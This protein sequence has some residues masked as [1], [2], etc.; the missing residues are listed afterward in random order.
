[1]VWSGGNDIKFDE[2]VYVST[3]NDYRCIL[4]K[5]HYIYSL[6]VEGFTSIEECNDFIDKLKIAINWF[7]LKRVIG[8]KLPDKLNEVKLYKVPIT[9]AEKSGLKAVTDQAGWSVVDGDYN[10]DQLVIIQENMKLTRWETGK[11]A[12]LLSHNAKKVFEDLNE[13]LCFDNVDDLRANKKLRLAV[14]LFSA[15]KFEVTTT[16]KF[17]KLVTVLEALLPDSQINETS[18]EALGLAKKAVKEYINKLK[19]SGENIQ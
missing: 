17:V 4:E 2:N 7:S 12:F 16:G 13:C 14:E 6:K 9:I 3:V 19:K 10:A 8:I 18:L 5:H 11:A 15:F 1:M